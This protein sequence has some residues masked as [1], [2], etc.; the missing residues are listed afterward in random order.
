MG[1]NNFM[2]KL[3]ELNTETGLTY[4]GGMEE[5]YYEILEEYCNADLLDVLERT[6]A[7]E[8]WTNYIIHA[9]ALK[10]TSLTIGAET[11]SEEAK[12]LEMAGK[13][14]RYDDIRKNHAA[15]IEHYKKVLEHIR[16]A[17]KE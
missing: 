13:E 5:I 17:I 4:C 15:V 10:S 7:E 16:E 1:A 6:F 12:G 8:D 9:H 3:T 2:S 14:S 11:L